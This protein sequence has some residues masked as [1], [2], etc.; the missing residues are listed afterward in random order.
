[1]GSCPRLHFILLTAGHYK[2]GDGARASIKSVPSLWRKTFALSSSSCLFLPMF[3]MH[4]AS[5][6]NIHKYL[7]AMWTML[8]EEIVI[9]SNPPDVNQLTNVAKTLSEKPVA[10]IKTQHHPRISPVW[11]KWGQKS[12]AYWQFGEFCHRLQAWFMLSSWGHFEKGCHYFCTRLK[13]T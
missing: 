3:F 13:H 11:F 8:L 1:M 9:S 6:R 7:F 4:S 12:P 2:R 5:V 10:V